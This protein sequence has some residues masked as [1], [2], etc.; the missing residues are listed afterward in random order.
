M[1][2]IYWSQHAMQQQLKGSRLQP[3]SGDP[4]DPP[5][6]GTNAIAPARTQQARPSGR[7]R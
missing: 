6:E 4:D 7:V 3:L 1:E 5:P 2:C